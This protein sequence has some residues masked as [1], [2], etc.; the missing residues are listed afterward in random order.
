MP[1]REW[2]DAKIEKFLDELF[3]LISPV[4]EE[5][6]VDTPILTPAEEDPL[7]TS[8]SN[9]DNIISDIEIM[10]IKKDEN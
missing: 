7:T 3:T 2:L 10:D 4:I 5:L 9:I 8:T 6:P 1:H